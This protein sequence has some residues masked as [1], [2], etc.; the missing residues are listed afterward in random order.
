[1][2][3]SILDLIFA[4]VFAACTFSLWML[5]PEFADTAIAVGLWSLLAAIS[6]IRR[7]RTLIYFSAIAAVAFVVRYAGH[8]DRLRS[9][10]FF[11]EFVDIGSMLCCFG[12]VANTAILDRH[13]LAWYLGI[14]ALFVVFFFTP[15]LLPIHPLISLSPM[16]IISTGLVLTWQRGRAA[17]KM[18]E[19]CDSHEAPH[20]DFRN[21]NHIG[22]AR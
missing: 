21:G 4:T 12:I 5:Y 17:L 11:A 16:M 15:F 14:A 9:P 3:A 20:D 1:M 22:G 7:K 13:N 19:P 2:K 18:T 10:Y 6:C 8:L